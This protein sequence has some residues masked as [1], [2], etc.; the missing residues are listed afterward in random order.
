[1][2]RLTDWGRTWRRNETYS[3]GFRG[4]V[5]WVGDR[6][7]DWWEQEYTEVPPYRRGGVGA[8]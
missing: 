5:R 4:G 1:M 2:L 8:A 7:M 3:R 6:F